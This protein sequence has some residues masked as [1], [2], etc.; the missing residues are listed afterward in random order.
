MADCAIDA[1]GARLP[2]AE[3]MTREDNPMT[4]ITWFPLIVMWHFA[5]A[6]P[7]DICSYHGVSRNQQSTPNCVLVG[8]EQRTLLQK[9]TVK[10]TQ[11]GYFLGTWALNLIAERL[12]RQTSGSACCFNL[13]V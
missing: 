4:F 8:M 11:K 7:A 12:E 13:P 3:T 9:C 5:P 1:M 6:A 10:N 2:I